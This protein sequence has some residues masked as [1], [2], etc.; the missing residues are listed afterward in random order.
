MQGSDSNNHGVRLDKWLWAAR[1]FK[2]RALAAEAITGGKVK[3]NG[4]RAK[5]AKS[6]RAGDSM[7]IRLGPY[8]HAIRV[9]GL[10][11][12]RGPASVAAL[13]YE[14]SAE[15][16]EARKRLAAQLAAERAYLPH[17]K[18]RPNKRERREILRFKQGGER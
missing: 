15:S 13:L 3:V 4:E 18:S 10:S 17:T 7:T 1:F 11:V 16:K 2:T 14:E 12:R 6:I 9:L 5:P 8:E